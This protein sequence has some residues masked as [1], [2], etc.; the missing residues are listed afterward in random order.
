MNINDL[1]YI[2]KLKQKKYRD[3]EKLFIIE[4]KHLIEE[5]LNSEYFS[6]KLQKIILR[7]DFDDKI[8]LEKITEF[9]IETL[10]G[11]DFRK[12]TETV[13]SQGIIGI[14]KMPEQPQNV[15]RKESASKVVVALENVNDPGNLGTILR[16]CYWF[17][18]NEIIISENSV[19]LY[20]SK[21]IRASQ[22]A[23]F[24]VN[25]Y[26]DVNL[27]FELENYRKSGYE[28]F[29]TKLDSHI[30]LNENIFS[31][32]KKYLFVFGNE[33]NGISVNLKK[34]VV[35]SGIRIKSYS[36]CESLN[37]ATSVGIVLYEMNKTMT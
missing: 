18:V 3:S 25:I 26:C 19:D 14:V 31:K 2:G 6:D 28:I 29:F 30:L 1:K 35:H 7:N 24:N 21:V 8:F 36:K 4:G 33:A 11:V 5:C 34:S 12:L 23:I 15:I 27:P 37:L 16:T 9:S 10:S 13:N 20:N 17:G 22:G 32:E